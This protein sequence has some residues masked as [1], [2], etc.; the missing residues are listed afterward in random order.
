MKFTTASFCLSLLWSPALVLGLPV[1]SNTGDIQGAAYFITND[2]SGNYVV[3]ADIQ[4]DGSLVYRRAVLAGGRGAHGLANPVGPDALFSQGSVKTSA[5]GQILATV[6]AGSNTLAVFNIDQ[7]RPSDLTMLGLPVSSEGEFPMSLAINN[8]GNQVCVLNGGQVNGVICFDVDQQLGLVSNPNTLRSLSLNQ[9]TPATGPAGSAS[10][11]IF[12]EDG[13]QL[14][15][16]IK[17]I[18]PTPGFLAIWDIADDGSLSENF[19]SVAPPNGGLLP[20]SMTSIPGTSAVLV[21]DPGIGF[22]IFDLSQTDNSSSSSAV[23]INGQSATCWS[24]F[25]NKTGNFYLTDV[26]TSIV[27][28]VNVDQNLTGT[29]V[30]QYPQQ[31]TSGT[32][33]SD[34]AT[35]GGNDFLYVLAPGTTSIQVLALNSPGNATNFGSFDVAG[36]LTEAGIIINSNNLQGMTVYVKP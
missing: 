17:G 19:T 4:S 25:S 5:T 7:N 16:S 9:T 15:A 36:P 8:D 18:P 22:D 31:S 20:F 2:P 29:V 14:I 33:D 24:S 35:I 28:E 32:I 23:P 12:S 26:G 1:R 6:N 34:I 30:N 11:I 3:S 21:T 10:D 13:T 27:T